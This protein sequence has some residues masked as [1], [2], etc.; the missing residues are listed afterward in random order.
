MMEE[1]GKRNSR[2]ALKDVV[3]EWKFDLTKMFKDKKELNRVI[4]EINMNCKDSKNVITSEKIINLESEI[5]EAIK[6]TQA[7][8]KEHNELPNKDKIS[9]VITDI[10]GIDNVESFGFDVISDFTDTK[11]ILKKW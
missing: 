8:E 5:R 4:K 9:K 11:N 6:N 7:L 1:W 2:G 3:R 10:F